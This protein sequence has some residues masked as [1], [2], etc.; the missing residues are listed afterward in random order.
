MTTDIIA[1][2]T[3]IVFGRFLSVVRF[4]L[5]QAKHS[6]TSLRQTYKQCEQE[7]SICRKY[8]L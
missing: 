8:L 6:C 7:N 3:I 1:L 2:I 5:E 4:R